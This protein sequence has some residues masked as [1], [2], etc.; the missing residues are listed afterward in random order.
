MHK[1]SPA[2][3]GVKNPPCNAGGPDPIPGQG[4]KIPHAVK[5]LIPHTREPMCHN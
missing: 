2:G 5:Q 4:T 1:D 3:P